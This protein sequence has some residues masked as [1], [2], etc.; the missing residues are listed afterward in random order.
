MFGSTDLNAEIAVCWKLV[1]NVE[2]AALIVPL[3][4]LVLAEALLDVVLLL[5]AAD[6]ELDEEHAARPRAVATAATP[7]VV[8]RCLRPN[9]ISGTP[10]RFWI[11]PRP[12]EQPPQPAGGKPG[13]A[14]TVCPCRW[15]ARANV[16]WTDR[17]QKVKFWCPGF[18]PAA[19]PA[20]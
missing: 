5:D 10:F 2:P 9:G 3:T 8:T 15:N 7:T 14:S 20:G 13:C 12:R 4:V 17:D 11:S 19:R 16:K 6:V 1:W 18:A